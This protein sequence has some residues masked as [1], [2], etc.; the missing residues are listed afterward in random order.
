MLKTPSRS[1]EWFIYRVA[2]FLA[3]RSCSTPSARSGRVL[4]SDALGSGVTCR[5]LRNRK[6]LLVGRLPMICNGKFLRL[7][8]M[9]FWEGHG[10]NLHTSPPTSLKGWVSENDLVLVFKAMLQP[11]KHL[12]QKYFSISPYHRV[13]RCSGLMCCSFCFCPSLRRIY[14]Y[15]AYLLITYCRTISPHMH[16]PRLALGWCWLR[17]AFSD[18]EWLDINGNGEVSRDELGTK[19]CRSKKMSNLDWCTCTYLNVC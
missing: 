4:G 2:S 5:M 19:A 17:W 12:R 1:F 9:T 15:C 3:F 13:Q 8:C 6:R 10:A 11:K 14:N 7:L 18:E 16:L